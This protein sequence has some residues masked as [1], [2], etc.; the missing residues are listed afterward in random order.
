MRIVFWGSPAFAA[1]VLEAVAGSDHGICGIVTRPPR[2]KGRGRK[3]VPTPVARAG[4][5]LGVPVLEPAKPRG[6]EFEDALAALEPHV[7]L[8]A[9]YGEILPPEILELPIHG[10]LNVH[11]SLLP[12]Y[13]GAA[14]VTR[15]LLD[16]VDETGVTIM[17]MDE[18]LDTGPIAL[19]AVE[20]VRADDTAGTLTKRLASLGGR[21]AVEALDR[22]ERGD[23]PSTP[24]DDADAS[25]A[26][27][28][29]SA[30]AELD[31]SRP[32]DELE[33]TVRAF[34]PWPGAWTTWRGGRLKVF[35]LE[36]DELPAG[37]AGSPGT[38]LDVETDPLVRVGQ[39]AV[40]LIETQPAGRRRMSGA[41]WARGRGIEPGVRLGE[42]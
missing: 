8:V 3:T 40:R 29:A 24:Q 23:L 19:Q 18:G 28:I 15:A 14:P 21:L 1:T 39:G 34:D 4:R 31:W 16:G 7:S 6:E 27:K 42:R 22:L 38:I 12:A 11:A 32:A 26:H 13:R 10:S 9:A 2:R 5:E 17:R 33:R 25:Y 37:A 30:E 36:P 20:P 35:R 41:A